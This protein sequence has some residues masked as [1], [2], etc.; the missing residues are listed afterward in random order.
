MRL[1]RPVPLRRSVLPVLV[2]VAFAVASG[3]SRTAD[4]QVGLVPL[5]AARAPASVTAAAGPSR[6]IASTAATAAVATF[7]YALDDSSQNL[8]AYY[9]T[10]WVGG[11]GRAA[12]VVIHGGSWANATKSASAATSAKFFGEGFAVF[13]INFRVTA[14]SGRHPG[15]PWPAQRV[16]T[17]LAVRWIKANATRFGVDPHRIA[18]YG[19]S[20]AGQIA[21]TASGYYRSVRAAVSVAGV[22]QPHRVMDIAVKGTIG[23][24]R[25][26]EQLVTLSQWESLAVQ[27]PYLSTWVECGGR[28]RTFKPETYFASVAPPFY[29]VMGDQDL[30]V[31]RGTFSGIEYWADRAGQRHVN[32]LVPGFGHSESM[33]TGS[34]TRWAAMIAWLRRETA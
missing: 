17:E 14:P 9:D 16:D 2:L 10:R 3:S 31:P 7:A 6:T 1:G 26:T 12:V 27:C 34:P 32:I 15:T 33:L 22:L 18:L 8:D 4:A 23:A 19:S 29:A 28:W 25:R 20:S 5:A 30:V 21:L 11:S 24:D 13:N